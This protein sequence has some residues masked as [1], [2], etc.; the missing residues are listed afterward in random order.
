[1]ARP[2]PMLDRLALS[3]T[4]TENLF[5]NFPNSHEVS[6]EEFPVHCLEV[7]RI[8]ISFQRAPCPSQ[9]AEAPVSFQGCHLLLYNSCSGSPKMMG[10]TKPGSVLYLIRQSTNQKRDVGSSGSCCPCSKNER[11]ANPSSTTSCPSTT[12]PRP[13]ISTCTCRCTCW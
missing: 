5:Y 13:H 7:P 1:M 3:W 11:I 6:S 2:W 4:W 10:V 8:Q 9:C 12:K